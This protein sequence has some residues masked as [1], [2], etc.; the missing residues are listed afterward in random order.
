MI[1]GPDCN[2]N[3]L[4]TKHQLP[5]ARH[6]GVLQTDAQTHE[7]TKYNNVHSASGRNKYPQFGRWIVFRIPHCT[8]LLVLWLFEIFHF[9]ASYANFLTWNG[10]SEKLQIASG[11][12]SSCSASSITWSYM[13]LANF[14]FLCR[15]QIFH[16]EWSFRKASD[17]FGTTPIVSGI[18]ENIILHIFR[19]FQL[20]HG[21][22]IG[23]LRVW[24]FA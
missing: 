13:V 1:R 9:F 8:F 6:T 24:R 14:I 18:I 22:T 12:C 20:Q 23:Y 21:R 15:M 5:Q 16:L 4:L 11:P 2:T 10:P 17:R 7:Q 19:V 3:P